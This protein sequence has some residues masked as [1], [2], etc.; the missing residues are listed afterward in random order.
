LPHRS[1]AKPVPEDFFPLL[2]ATFLSG[3]VAYELS[4][5]AANHRTRDLVIDF[6]GRLE[7]AGRIVTP[8]LRDWSE[9]GEIVTRIAENERSWRTKLP[10]LLNDILIALPA[11]RIG[12][13]V[14]TY[15][16][17]LPSHP[18]AQTFFCAD[19]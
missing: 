2:P 10:R 14:L 15:R 13:T 16:R 7:R 4:V 12:A 3:I 19:S 9:A 6:V 1:G 8:T 11:R 5:N 17:R 18:P